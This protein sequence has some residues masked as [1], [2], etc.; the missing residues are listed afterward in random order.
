MMPSGACRDLTQ[1]E[2]FRTVNKQL[3]MTVNRKKS[4][5]T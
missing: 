3:R 5:I 4:D 2:Y 1:E